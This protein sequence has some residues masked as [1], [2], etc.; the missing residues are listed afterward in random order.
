MEA[1]MSKEAK[2]GL[3]VLLAVLVMVGGF[4]TWRYLIRRPATGD[5]A[6]ADA[7]AIAPDAK[8]SKAG[9]AAAGAAEAKPQH[10]R[11]RKDAPKTLAST[12]GRPP[13]N[14][15]D[16][17]LAANWSDYRR[18][19]EAAVRGPS[20][21]PD[22]PS[23]MPEPPVPARADP[24]DRY[25]LGNLAASPSVDPMGP[26]G[27]AAAIA[28]DGPR[29][30][31]NGNH[32]P[33][34]RRPSDRR[35]TENENATGIGQPDPRANRPD[36]RQQR[37]PGPGGKV[38]ELDDGYTPYNRGPAASYTG[39][40]RH[41]YGRNGMA[42]L[43]EPASMAKNGSRGDGTYDVQPNDN[44]WTV[45]EK[46]YGTGAYFEALEELNRAKLVD[47][48]LKVGQ[49][50]LTPDVAELEKRFPKKCPKE[51]HREVLQNHDAIQVSTQNLRNFGGRTYT[52]VEGDT[53]FDIARYELGKASRWAEIYELNRTAL[54]R[55]FDYLVPG[56]ELRLP[57]DNTERGDPVTRRG[58]GGPR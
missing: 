23:M 43:N 20:A 3:G 26:P 19:R 46:M 55:D 25:G 34:D 18:Q 57:G 12:Q 17:D 58:W 52:V 16:R 5:A 45:S 39:R 41:P 30:V 50:I 36:D 42:G 33:D 35:L 24:N 28:G 8:D 10:P 54:G 37:L 49:N 29:D 11:D 6:V 56:T 13:H 51:N 31:R 27:E 44:L 1:D 53:L 7:N 2:I 21:S 38:R 32:R 48:Q 22:A 4:V 15:S 9:N 14:D 40:E 47:G